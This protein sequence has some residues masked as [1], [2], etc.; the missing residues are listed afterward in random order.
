MATAQSNAAT[1]QGRNLTG[2]ASRYTESGSF[3]VGDK[4]TYT[5]GGG[6]NVGARANL[7]IN[8][9]PE[10]QYSQIAGNVTIGDPGASSVFANTVRDISQA[11]ASA[12]ERLLSGLKEGEKEGKGDESI[13]DKALAVW[14]NIPAAAKWGGL[15]L[16]L[17][18]G[19][20]FFF[21]RR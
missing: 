3:Q 10:F 19:W 4:A 20:W 1:D 11:N 6:V 12:T 17:V 5:E 15:A 7:R 21:K 13:A 14:K 9:A 16:L 18:G 2:R 8:N